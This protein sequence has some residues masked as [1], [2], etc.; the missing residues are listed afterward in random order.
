MS[1]K[2]VGVGSSLVSKLDDYDK[3]LSKKIQD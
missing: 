3:K 1:T 2:T